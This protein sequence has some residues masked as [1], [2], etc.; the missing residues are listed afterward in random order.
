VYYSNSTLSTKKNSPGWLEICQQ[1]HLLTGQ[2]GAQLLLPLIL[3][4]LRLCLV[5]GGGRSERL[6]TVMPSS[7]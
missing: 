2:I 6:A 5:K 3:V 7:F 1:L 4:N